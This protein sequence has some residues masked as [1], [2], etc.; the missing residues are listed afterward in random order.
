MLPHP[1][2]AFSTNWLPEGST[3]I[4]T[5]KEQ[6]H[7]TFPLIVSK[8]K[9]AEQRSLKTA[10]SYDLFHHNNNNNHH[11]N[12]LSSDKNFCSNVFSLKW[13]FE[14]IFFKYKKIALCPGCVLYLLFLAKR[15][16]RVIVMKNS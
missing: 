1:Y 5:C 7:G 4:Y 6:G 14:K 2:I 3:S 11:Y 10:F 13:F 16:K 15:L 9:V 12:I 8:Q